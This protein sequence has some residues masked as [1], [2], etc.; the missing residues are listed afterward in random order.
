MT[1]LADT[2]AQHNI[3]ADDLEKAASVRI[4]QKVASAENIDLSQL[5]PEQLEE[6]YEHF[7]ANVLPAIVGGGEPTTEAKIASLSEDDLIT[8]FDKQ[9]S[10]EGLDLSGAT[11][12]QLSDAFGFF[13]ENILPVMAENGFEPVTAEKSAEVEEAQA[14]LAEADI[15]GRQM[16]RGYADELA[17]IAATDDQGNYF[18]QAAKSKIVDDAGNA[19]HTGRMGKVKDLGLSALGKMRRN[20]KTTAALGVGALAVGGGALALRKHMKAEKETTAGVQ[21]SV[22]D[23][24]ILSQLADIGDVAGLQKAASLIKNAAAGGEMVHVPGKGSAHTISNKLRQGG[25]VARKAVTGGYG[26]GVQ[27]ATIGGGA[28]LAAGG[29]GAALA[30]HMKSKASE[31]KE[32]TADA[33]IDVLV[34]ERATDLAAEW[35]VANG[36]GS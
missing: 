17:K 13:L 9:A 12:E 2:L 5:A 20:P 15:L 23:V 3:S 6:L 1:T 28:A 27:A 32:A 4:F 25:E 29:V 11:E 35:L 19:T 31:G 7:E 8:L 21:L 24:E 16:A 14:K 22:E 18:T 34:E 30:H 36:Y 10:A 26:R 33:V